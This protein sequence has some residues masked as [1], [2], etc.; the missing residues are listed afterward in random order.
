[1]VFPLLAPKPTRADGVPSILPPSTATGRTVLPDTPGEG[2]ES[3][4]DHPAAG[5]R[6]SA[7]LVPA[8][9]DRGHPSLHL[10]QYSPK[11]RGVL[12]LGLHLSKTGLVS[13]T[14]KRADTYTI[15]VKCSDSSHSHKTQAIQTLT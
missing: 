14:T 13:G 4:H 8:P 5:H 7:L 9:G 1:M 10:D 11:G 12:P 2:L 15:T 6:R 3:D